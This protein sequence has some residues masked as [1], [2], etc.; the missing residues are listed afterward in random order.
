MLGAM[1]LTASTLRQDI[2]RILDEVLATGEPV[3]IRRHGRL[4][5]IV[6][7]EVPGSRLARVRTRA[8]AVPGDPEDLVHTDWS[9]LWRP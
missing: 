7:D 5:R 3:E 2:Y 1:E 8:G 4:L 6:A 9:D